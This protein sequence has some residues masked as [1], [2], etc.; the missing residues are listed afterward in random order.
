MELENLVANSMLLRARLEED[1]SSLCDKQPIG[2]LLFREFCNTRDN[3]KR[4]IEFLD[5]VA[6]YEIT[7]DEDR[8]ECG[9]LILKTFFFNETA[10]A[11]LPRIPARVVRTCRLRLKEVPSKELFKEC[12]RVVHHFLSGKPFEEYQESPYFSRFLQWKWLERFMPVK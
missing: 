3:L 9:Q 1:Y 4:C 5:A 7:L 12:V 2:R 6:E 11:P 8:R 10:A